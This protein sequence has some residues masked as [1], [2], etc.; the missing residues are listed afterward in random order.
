ME[1]FKYANWLPRFAASIIDSLI[2]AVPTSLSSILLSIFILNANYYLIQTA[3]TLLNFTIYI[4]YFTILLPKNGETPGYKF[5]GLK[6]IK[7]D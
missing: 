4:V 6:I 3:L 2:L 5:L 1:N 7:E